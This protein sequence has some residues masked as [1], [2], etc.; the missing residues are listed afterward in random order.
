[1]KFADA[2]NFKVNISPCRVLFLKITF[3]LGRQ[4][5]NSKMGEFYIIGNLLLS[6]VSGPCNIS[7]NCIT[8]YL[9]T[10]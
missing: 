10:E 5:S 6:F 8:H 3:K 7:K 4:F 1:V 2:E 9:S